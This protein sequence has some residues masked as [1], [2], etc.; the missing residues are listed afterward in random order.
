[1]K[2]NLFIWMVPFSFIFSTFSATNFSL[3]YRSPLLTDDIKL[4]DFNA[5]AL[6]STKMDCKDLIIVDETIDGK[7]QVLKTKSQTLI[8]R[9]NYTYTI[10]LINDKRGIVA[11][12]YSYSGVKFN[13]GDELIFMDKSKNRILCSFIGTGENA[14]EGEASVHYNILNL[15]AKMID[16]FS[17][18]T[19][20]TVYIKNNI[21]NEMRKFTINESRR[22]EFKQLAKCFNLNLAKA[23]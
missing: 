7:I 11:K 21:K 3:D 16:W 5:S 8:Q 4:S 22:A 12:V 14:T 2:N 23:N 17:T 13:K 10:E 1:M 18:N 9:G 19:I 15:D 6:N 20:T